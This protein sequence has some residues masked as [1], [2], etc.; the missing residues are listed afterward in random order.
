MVAGLVEA[1]SALMV[2]LTDPDSNHSDH[3]DKQAGP[4]NV[5]GRAD[6][7]A[8][9]CRGGKASE[10]PP[11]SGPAVLAEAAAVGPMLERGG[12][13][14]W[15]I[16]AAPTGTG[17]DPVSSRCRQHHQR[18]TLADGLA[19]SGGA[20]TCRRLLTAAAQAAAAAAVPMSWPDG[21]VRH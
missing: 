20:G 16:A 17:R 10:R 14:R 13:V 9:R 2:G 19:G 1:V 12:G 15:R 21:R 8:G 5:L 3:E 7:V 11:A 4:D 18:G 6:S